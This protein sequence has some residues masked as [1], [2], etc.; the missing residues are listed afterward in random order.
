MSQSIYFFVVSFIVFIL[1]YFNNNS[2]A[3][4]NKVITNENESQEFNI[5]ATADVG[6]SLRAQE[7]IKNIEKLQPE[8]FL[9]AGDL[10][11]K[12]TPDCWFN[13]TKSLDSKTKIAI[14]NHDDFEEEGKKGENLK[15]SYLNHY[16]LPHSY[17][18]FD[19]RNVH[20]LVL[21]TQLELSI[22]T[23]EST[24]IINETTSATSLI[25][26]SK[27]D[28][29]DKKQDKKE[30][31][32]T[33][34]KIKKEPLLE[35]FPLVDL[36]NFLKQNSINIEIPE[37]EKLIASNAKVPA[38]DVNEDQYNFVLDNLK[39][40]SQNKNIDWIIVMFHKPMYSSLSKQFE[41]Y[42][43]RDK[44]QPIFDKY[45]VDLVI[46]GH[47][48]IYSR[49]LPL[50]FNTINISQ[51][52]IDP[53]SSNDGN[54]TSIFTNPNGTIFLVVGLGGGELHRITDEPYYIANQYNE[55]FGFAD[56][57]IDGKRLDEKFYD[58]NLNCQ[59]EIT[60][61]KKKEAIDLES[62]LPSN[63]SNNNLKIIDQFTIQKF[64]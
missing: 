16:N 32:D 29:K 25:D 10:S 47:N 55:G 56:L 52:I 50:S 63:T 26:V 2:F 4:E 20:V 28:S 51:P 39:K 34:E 58:I 22:D 44:Y 35:R 33:G 41:E 36:K 19:Y 43:I 3:I 57:K 59:M 49:T 27:E 17:Y 62:C 1:L 45:G 53:N 14:G 11:Y 5:I 54:N 8:L 30:K 24:A 61:K 37:L 18:S 15:N 42:I 46:S 21:D 60:E 7:N 38:F 40:N 23:L 9:V 13:I 6:C 12:K 64:N 48:H 31:N